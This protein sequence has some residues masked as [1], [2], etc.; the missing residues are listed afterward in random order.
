MSTRGKTAKLAISISHVSDE[1][2]IAQKSA[3][4]QGPIH[5]LASAY[6][7]KAL[8]LCKGSRIKHLCEDWACS[9]DVKAFDI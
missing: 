5:E 4:P 9:E 1:I 2:S 6:T 7:V 8:R 3:I